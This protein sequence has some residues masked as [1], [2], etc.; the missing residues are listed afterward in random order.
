M[1]IIYKYTCKVNQK[2]YIGQTKHGLDYRWN[3]HMWEVRHNPKNQS[4]Y[5]NNAI[6]EHKPENFI[7]EILCE[8]SAEEIDEKE[9]HYIVHFN[10]L[11]P[12]GF[13]LTSGGKNKSD[14][15]EATRQKLSKA[16][17]GK[18]KNITVGRKNPEDN[19][20]PKYIKHYKDSRGVEGYKV[21]DHPKL[22]KTV[23]YTTSSMSMEEKYAEA[24]FDLT[25][26]NKN[27]HF[28]DKKTDEKYVFEIPGGYR[29]RKPTCPIKRFIDKTSAI[30]YRNSL[31][32][33][34]TTK[35]K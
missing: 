4:Y 29:V 13:N 30:A 7:R 28:P 32:P 6:R 3:Q 16:L 5:L 35:R 27:T 31:V 1:P 21:A 34:S 9:R 14:I 20:L 22:N 11:A 23:C 2:S 24:L 19:H 8:C 26:L 33:S 17:R 15:S 25:N 18:P 12:N 10:T